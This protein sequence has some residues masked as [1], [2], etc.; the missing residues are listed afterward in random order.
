[1]QTGITTRPRHG[2]RDILFLLRREM[3]LMALVFLVI[4]A[5]GVVAVLTLKESY[6][7]TGSLFVGP[8]TEYVDLSRSGSSDRGV[9]VTISEMARSEGAILDSLEVKRRVVRA[10]GA[11][12]FVGPVTGAVTPI[13]EARALQ[14]VDQALVIEIAPQSPV[15]TLSYTGSDARLAAQVLNT[16]IDQYLTYR[17][18]LF[19]DRTTPAIGIQRLAFEEELGAADRAYKE[20]LAN[21]QIGDFETVKTTLGASYQTVFGE[22]LATQ[23]QLGQATRRLLT[24]T[25]QL[26][27]TPSQ[28]TLHQ[29]LSIS[30]QDQNRQ[31]QAGVATG[32]GVDVK[33]M[34]TGLNPVWVQLETTRILTRAERDSLTA[35]LAVLERQ[36]DDLRNRQSRLIALESQ[37]ATLAGYR[38]LLSR[39]VREFHLHEARSRASSEQVWARTDIMV[40]DRAQQP[41]R[42]RNLKLPLMALVIFLATFIALCTGLRRVFQQ[43][44]VMTPSSAERTFGLPVLAVVPAK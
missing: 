37:N 21:N 33:E 8:G 24:L 25:S 32:A 15:I 36:L 43:R 17:K 6:T 29:N 7:A 9:Q 16:V 35:R 13:Q 38:E 14:A 20:F 19:R 5:V 18:E 12:S 30:P 2:V 26:A 11:E 41:D 23:A 31:L 28:I 1:M 10:M 34:R 39:A 27:A 3:R 44:G 4:C 42:S 22:R 40:I